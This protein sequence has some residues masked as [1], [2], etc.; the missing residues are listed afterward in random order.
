MKHP[1]HKAIGVAAY[2]GL[3]VFFYKPFSVAFSFILL[4]SS[5]LSYFS[6]ILPD[7]I[8]KSKKEHRGYT[9]SFFWSIV[10]TLISC[11]LIVPLHIWLKSQ[12][13]YFPVIVPIFAVWIGYTSHFIADYFTNKG[14]CIWWPFDEERKGYKLWEHEDRDGPE[15]LITI[16][17]WVLTIIIW[18]RHFSFYYL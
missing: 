6:S 15:F 12:G 3:I 11:N 8:E 10:I 2:S 5:I 9:H 4:A 18:I 13:V 17:S 16:I 1:T 14:V 7:L